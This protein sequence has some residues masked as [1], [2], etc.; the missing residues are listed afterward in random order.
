MKLALRTIK[1]FDQQ[2]A[3]LCSSHDDYPLF[4]SLPGSGTVYSSRLLAAFGSDRQRFDSA[5]DVA[6]LSGIAPVIECS[7]QSS[8]IRWRYFCP[9]FLRQSFTE[10]AGRGGQSLSLQEDLRK[11]GSP[12][13]SYAANNPHL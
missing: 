3:E 7:G 1:E 6:R 2:I 9:K 13:L 5:G 4:A 11:K 10:Y 8:W 12:L